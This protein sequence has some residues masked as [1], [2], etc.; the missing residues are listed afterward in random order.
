MIHPSPRPHRPH[1]ILTASTNHTTP[2]RSRLCRGLHIGQ[3]EARRLHQA[4]PLVPRQRMQHGEAG[5]VWLAQQVRYLPLLA[6]GAAQREAATQLLTLQTGN[7]R[8]EEGISRATALQTHYVLLLVHNKKL[9]LCTAVLGPKNNC[10]QSLVR[11]SSQCRRST[12]APLTKRAA[13]L[14]L[15]SHST[16]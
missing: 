1:M 9:L 5:R 16:T 14:Q 13:T 8:R 4:L 15:P 7:G 12:A 10:L 2:R 11:L 3:E 6:A